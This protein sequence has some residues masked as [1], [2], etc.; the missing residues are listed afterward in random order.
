MI[1]SFTGTKV[2]HLVIPSKK[3]G[4]SR[5]RIVGKVV[6]VAAPADQFGF[7]GDPEP[8]PEIFQTPDGRKIECLSWDYGFRS[9]V[10]RMYQEG[11]GRIPSGVMGLLKQNIIAEL[12]GVLHF[13]KWYNQPDQS[14]SA[15]SVQLLQK[16]DE[17]VLDDEAVRQREIDACANGDHA[18]ATAPTYI[19]YFYHFLCNTLDIFYV[20]RPFARFWV[21]EVVARIPYF[22]YNSILHLY[23]SLGWWR[24]GGELR[25]LHFAEEWNELHHLQIMETLG[26]DAK[27]FDRFLAHHAALF[28][29][30]FAMIF[31]LIS[32]K[33]SYHFMECI[34]GHARDT[35]TEFLEKNKEKLEALPPPKVAC[36]Y[37][38]GSDLYMFDELQSPVCSGDRHVR[39]VRRPDCNNLYDV[40]TNIRDDEIEHVKTMDSCKEQNFSCE[41]DWDRN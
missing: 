13:D 16:L 26:G 29:F 8:E 19:K 22:A 27:W 9:G 2:G 12:N 6:A 38:M 41:I 40:F 11:Y 7:T 5:K 33:H 28:Y 10:E 23:E 21:L 20:G 25:R 34:E 39:C 3:A 15:Y 31:Y 17:L 32:P 24:A 18:V 37:Y 1:S 4:L 14:T 35:Y 36:E 30:W